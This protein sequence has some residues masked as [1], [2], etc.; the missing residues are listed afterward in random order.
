MISSDWDAAY[1][2]LL[3]AAHQVNIA[4]VRRLAQT[5]VPS[6]REACLHMARADMRQT[7]NPWAEKIVVSVLEGDAWK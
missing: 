4:E 1:D 6:I 3:T 5:F 7:S 2:K